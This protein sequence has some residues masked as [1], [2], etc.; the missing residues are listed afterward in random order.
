MDALWRSLKMVLA[1]W[2]TLV[3]VGVVWR[4]YT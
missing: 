4:L 1:V 2:I 3:F